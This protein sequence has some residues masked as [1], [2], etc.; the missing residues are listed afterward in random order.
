M[1]EQGF[2][3]PDSDST[4]PASGPLRILHLEDDRGDAELVRTTLA[5]HG[6]ACQIVVVRG[7]GIARR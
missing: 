2:Q 1:S 3:L 6:V 5:Q 4:P 7:T